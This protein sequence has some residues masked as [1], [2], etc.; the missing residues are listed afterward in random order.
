MKAFW[1]IIRLTCRSAVRTH[2]FRG[3]LLLL[4]GVTFGVP[5]FVKSDGTAVGMIRI[6]LEYCFSLTAFLLC[7]SAVWFGGA[8]ITSDVTDARLHMI[9]SKPVSRTMVFLAKFTGVLLIH[10]VLLILAAGIIYGLTMYRIH[11]AELSPR[12]E[13]V[14]KHEVLTARKLYKPEF[15]EDE[16]NKA[17]EEMLERM[18]AE[19]RARGEE[20]PEEWRYARNDKGQFDRAEILKRM[21][22]TY[23]INRDRIV[24][25]DVHVWK[26]P[27]LPEDLDGPV[28]I[29]F[30]IYSSETQS[31]QGATYGLWGWRYNHPLKDSDTGER[32]DSDI[33]FFPENEDAS[34]TAFRQTELEIEPREKA[35]EK[36]AHSYQCVRSPLKFLGTGQNYEA[37]PVAFPGPEHRMVRNG[38]GT[39]LFQNLDRRHT[40]FIQRSDGPF[41]LVPE[42]GFISNYCRAV[43]A[44]FLEIAAFASLGTAFSACFSLPMG[45]L[46]SVSYVI[47]SAATQFVLQLF[48]ATA[49]KPHN[50]LEW[51]SFYAGRGAQY[52][53][54]GTD[55]FSPASMLASGEL[56]EF[57]VLGSQFL[58]NT[59]LKT[60]P[61]FLLGLYCYHRRELALAAKE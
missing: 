52:V 35:G 1:A 61:F 24:P 4:L 39:L 23:R 42:T 41:L 60:L 26:F 18:L 15:S 57:S 12:E 17:A 14:L 3:L 55:N 46:L 25:G 50:L 2:L 36:K 30:K 10:G 21:R 8:E 45:I 33:L 11:S 20:M 32:G 44:V 58:F 34:F 49:V 16:V 53:L 31:Q 48:T 40:L 13:E 27:G 37:V 54:I 51:I 43:L 6:T 56:I 38:T 29:R 28:R 5:L 7:V 22:E 47:F 59:V 9:V 19:A